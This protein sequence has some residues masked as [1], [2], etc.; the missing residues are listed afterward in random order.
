MISS[1]IAQYHANL[2]SADSV[3]KWRTALLLTSAA[4]GYE[5]FLLAL[6]ENSSVPR[7]N[8]DIY[9]NYPESWLRKYLKNEYYR[10]DPIVIHCQ[11]SVV[12]IAWNEELFQTSEQKSMRQEAAVHGL[13][14]GISFPISSTSGHIGVMSYASTFNEKAP[15]LPA[16]ALLGIT[17]DVAFDALRRLRPAK[18]IQRNEKPIKLT[19][20]EK[21]CIK[22]VAEGKTSWEASIIMQCAEATVNFHLTNVMNKYGVRTRQQAILKAYIDQQI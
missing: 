4:L 2:T 22:W 16:R 13:K 20:R 19:R 18:D 12:P 14:Y 7:S 5:Y 17:R 11:N 15:S 6:L 1:I 8:A 21:E 10:F 3:Q 9:T